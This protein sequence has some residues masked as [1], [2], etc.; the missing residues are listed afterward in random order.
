MTTKLWDYIVCPACQQPYAV[1]P[2][3]VAM[4]ITVNCLQ[5]GMMMVNV[6]WNEK[7]AKMKRYRS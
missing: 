6:E 4:G 2:P 7:F 3:A 5:C 1:E